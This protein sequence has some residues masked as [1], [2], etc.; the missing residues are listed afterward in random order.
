MGNPFLPLFQLGIRVGRRPRRLLQPAASLLAI[1][2]L[3]LHTPSQAA[4]QE[5]AEEEES[6]ANETDYGRITIIEEND[7]IYLDDDRYYS[8]GAQLSWLSPSIGPGSHFYTPFEALSGT[9]IFAPFRSGGQWHRQHYEILLGQQVF[10]PSDI[11]LSNPP[12]D[13]RPYGGWLYAGLGM[14]QDTD[15]RELDH[16]EILAGIIGPDSM[17]SNAQNDW[18]QFI[19]VGE[20]QG[21]RH[22][23]HSEPGVMI[24][25]ERKWRFNQPLFWGQE[26]EAIPEL[27]ATVGNVMT[28]GQT[29][30][31]LRFGQGLL[32]DYGQQRMRPATSGTGYFNADAMTSPFGYYFYVAAQGRAVGRNIF[33]DGNTFENSR[34]VDKKPLVGDLSAG[35]AMFW[36]DNFRL[37]ASATYRTKEFDG[38]DGNR[39]IFGGFNITFGL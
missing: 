29:G 2:C 7:S 30:I 19:G 4:A 33:L 8:Q 3:W 5:A 28:Y 22:E 35:L 26:I 1:A 24:S 13:D 6:R 37:D 12:S 32:A 27:G 9:S 20:A 36:S 34:S 39:V 11:S 23:I 17:A 31:T 14:V 38:Q 16:L 18:H 25:Y 15:H 21:W 10:T